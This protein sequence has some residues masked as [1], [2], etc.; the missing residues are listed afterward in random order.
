VDTAPALAIRTKSFWNRPISFEEPTGA[1]ENQLHN[2]AVM[3]DLS[4]ATTTQGNSEQMTIDAG[5][6]PRETG[7]GLLGFQDTEDLRRHSIHLDDRHRTH[8]SATKT[9]LIGTKRNA[10]G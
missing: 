5:G 2:L 1:R 4:R 10:K 7:V 6:R 8:S 3:P 9:A